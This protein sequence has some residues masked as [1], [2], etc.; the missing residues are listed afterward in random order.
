MI[1]SVWADLVAEL[2][3]AVELVLVVA[4]V[5][6][7]RATFELRPRRSPELEQLEPIEREPFDQ[8]RP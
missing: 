7:W 4:V 3:L 2:A 8:D 1:A 6:L 5:V